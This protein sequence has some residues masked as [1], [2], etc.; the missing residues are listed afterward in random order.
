MRI[1]ILF[2]LLLPTPPPPQKKIFGRVGKKDVKSIEKWDSKVVGEAKSIHNFVRMHIGLC[3]GEYLRVCTSRR[4]RENMSQDTRRDLIFHL[5]PNEHRYPHHI[6]HQ[7]NHRRHQPAAAAK[8]K[9]KPT[10]N[11]Q[12]SFSSP[13]S[14]TYLHSLLSCF[15][16]RTRVLLTFNKQSFW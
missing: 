5:H 16:F 11:Q 6:T 15:R 12:L 9:T 7:Q 13:K 2:L 14:A 1:V 10:K 4:R 8:K 3:G